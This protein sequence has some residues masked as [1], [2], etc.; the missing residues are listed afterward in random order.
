LDF[1]SIGLIAVGLAMDAFAV[2]I[3]CGFSIKKLKKRH[4][5]RIAFAFGLF[6]ALMPVAGWALGTSFRDLIA[7]FDH[8]IAMALLG[9]IGGKMLWEARE[10]CQKRTNLLDWHILFMMSLATSIDAFAVGLTF[11]VL[12]IS[13]I[14]PVIIIGVVTF[15]M[16]WAGVLLGERFGCFF[17][18][19]VERIGGLLLI[20]IGIKIV[21]EH[22]LTKT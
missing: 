9:F 14:T 7:G 20:A 11:A 4:A 19:K 17:G 8:W 21:I 12:A 5:F 16:S 18:R 2:S 22:I 15:G 10:S 13:I 3:S 6:Q 1:I